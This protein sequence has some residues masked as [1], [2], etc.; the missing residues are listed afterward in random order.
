MSYA[1]LSIWFHDDVQLPGVAS[2]ADCMAQC[3]QRGPTC[4]TAEFFPSTGTCN[5]AA[6]TARDEP[7]HQEA[8]SV[9]Y[10]YMQRTC[11]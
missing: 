8:D 6:V 7:P 3:V 9:T 4:R 11:S 5:L 2:A 10:V 1:G